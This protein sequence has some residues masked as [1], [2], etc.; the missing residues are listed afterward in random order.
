MPA[1]SNTRTEDMGLVGI[2]GWGSATLVT[3]PIDVCMETDPVAD[4]GRLVL[5]IHQFL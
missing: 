5:S 2:M 4:L 1:H 3:A